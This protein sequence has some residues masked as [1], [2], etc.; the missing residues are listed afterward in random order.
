M[1]KREVIE[2]A[3]VKTDAQLTAT[4]NELVANQKTID[5]LTKVIGVDNRRDEYHE[6]KSDL[7]VD[8]KVRLAKLINFVNPYVFADGTGKVLP[9]DSYENQFKK[10]M[11]DIARNKRDIKMLEDQIEDLVNEYQEVA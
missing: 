5:S 11:K 6:V 3:L 7:S 10:V 4:R 1:N 2:N 9:L 8:S